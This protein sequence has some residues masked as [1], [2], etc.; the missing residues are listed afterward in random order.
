[1][2]ESGLR[3]MTDYLG[4][5]CWGYQSGTARAGAGVLDIPLGRG[6]VARRAPT[7]GIQRPGP[8]W[9]IFWEGERRR[10]GLPPLSLAEQEE[11]EEEEREH[12]EW[13][14][15]RERER[16]ERERPEGGL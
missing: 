10:L 12:E 5:R 4:C 15:E 7:L 6:S 3:W 14:R 13:L 11:E 8:V 16:R 1:M 9:Q 2:V